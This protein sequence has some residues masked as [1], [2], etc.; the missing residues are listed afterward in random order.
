MLLSVV[1][2]LIMVGCVPTGGKASIDKA[3]DL[4]DDKEY[5]D[6][7]DMFEDLI[8]EDN[9][10]L[11]AYLGLVEAN[12]EAEEY[13]DAD[14]ALE[15]LQEV[16]IDLFDED[17]PD[18]MEK[19]IEGFLEFA[20]ILDEEEELGDWILDLLD[21]DIPLSDY[22]FDIS[23]L[24]GDVG[25]SG[26]NPNSG[27]GGTTDDSEMDEEAYA[28]LIQGYWVYCGT[29]DTFEDEP[30]FESNDT[31]YPYVE[32][33][34]DMIYVSISEMGDDFEYIWVIYS[35]PFEVQ[36]AAWGGLVGFGSIEDMPSMAE[37]MTL[38]VWLS[39]YEYDDEIYLMDQSS[40][41]LYQRG[42]PGSNDSA[43]N[44][45]HGSDD[46]NTD[47]PN[48]DNPNTDDPNTDNPNT[49]DPGHPNGDLPVVSM[50]GLTYDRA[51]E[52]FGDLSDGYI[53]N[54]LYLA[55][56]YLGNDD[57]FIGLGFEVLPDG[58]YGRVVLAGGDQ[59]IDDEIIAG[60][61]S[62]EDI[63]NM[64]INKYD[65]YAF[66]TY[67]ETF[68]FTK[69]DLY[70]YVSFYGDELDIILVVDENI[71]PTVPVMVAQLLGEE[72]YAVISQLGDT[73][74]IYEYN[75]GS[76]EMT[77]SIL[78]I[79]I[80][81]EDVYGNGTYVATDIEFYPHHLLQL[82]EGV[83][84]QGTLASEFE[85]MYGSLYTIEYYD[86]DY[87][88]FSGFNYYA[89]SYVYDGIIEEIELELISYDE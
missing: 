79:V 18:D 17:E 3:Y 23:F 16:I 35:G 14:K 83:K 28:E 8:D 73:Y 86:E 10:A 80:D 78:P 50:L 55:E 15:D 53:T 13:G 2:V 72:M 81:F 29:Y 12:I 54:N 5:D 82:A 42:M 88:D 27:S 65:N 67:N 48:T 9:D 56:V 25:H 60:V 44:D 68:S 30:T 57:L 89:E 34:D 21:S 51:E 22:D 33:D 77:Y 64:A 71:L 7:I 1:M 75:D 74:E 26:D 52:L 63:R 39:I 40:G 4:I 24:N 41:D 76:F 49:D 45:D 20:E 66:S 46:P 70:Y 43:N 36:E 47:D 37:G 32:I 6:A 69:D 87:L 58:S 85:A 61:T 62:I 84:V 38:P 19:E 11:E 59:Y 31:G